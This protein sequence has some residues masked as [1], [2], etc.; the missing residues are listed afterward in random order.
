M[1]LCA[2]QR[3]HSLLSLLPISGSSCSRCC[4]GANTSSAKDPKHRS[5]GL[6]GEFEKHRKGFC[7]QAGLHHFPASKALPPPE[8]LINLRTMA[9]SSPNKRT[10]LQRRDTFESE[11]YA[12]LISSFPFGLHW[13]LVKERRSRV[14]G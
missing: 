2:Y 13:F 6:S 1:R 5:L 14:L 10:F 7:S 8:Q 12:E 11:L 4:R 3:S 9:L